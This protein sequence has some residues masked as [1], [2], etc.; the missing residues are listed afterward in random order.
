MVVNLTNND[1]TW[2]R[3][4]SAIGDVIAFAS[5]RRL[6][7]NFEPIASPLEK[8]LKLNGCTFDWKSKVKEL[9]FYPTREKNEI[10]LIAQDVQA[11]IPQAVAPAPFDQ[12]W[13]NEEGKNVS[14][15]GEDYL[16]VKYEKLVPLLIEAIKEQQS[17]IE[18]L[19]ERVNQ[20][21]NN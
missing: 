7:E 19:T 20:L 2:G 3:N 9:G 6:K 5:D 1:V 12:E 21:E 11:V 4:V 8:V 16:T 10:G 14:K 15:S 18:A 13:D 17:Q